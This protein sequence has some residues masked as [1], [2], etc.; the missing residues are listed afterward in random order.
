MFWPGPHYRL[1]LRFQKWDNDLICREHYVVSLEHMNILLNWL[2]NGIDGAKKK[3]KINQKDVFNLFCWLLA[4][5]CFDFVL[6]SKQLLDKR[7]R[8]IGKGE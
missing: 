4:L 5:D 2:L 1:E 6:V 3:A 8:R 7:I